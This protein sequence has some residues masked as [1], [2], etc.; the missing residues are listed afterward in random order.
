MRKRFGRIPEKM[1]AL[2]EQNVRN[3]KTRVLIALPASASEELRAFTLEKVLDTVF[4][5]W[6]EHDNYN[7]LGDK[8]WNDLASFVQ[9]SA[10]IAGKQL[11]AQGKPIYEATLAALLE[12]WLHNWN[13]GDNDGPPDA[14][15]RAEIQ[16]AN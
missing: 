12:D 6:L 2:F 5:D 4:Q 13:D 9:M 16:F 15:A 8:D 10:A 1:L 3:V 14:Y 11:E 7:E